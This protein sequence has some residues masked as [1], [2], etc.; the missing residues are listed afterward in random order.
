MVG[1]TGACDESCLEAFEAT[2]MSNCCG[3]G[4]MTSIGDN[5]CIVV[6]SVD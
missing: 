2:V 6:V 4:A 1:V 5:V 3:T